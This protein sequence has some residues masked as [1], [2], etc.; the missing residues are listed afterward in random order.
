MNWPDDGTDLPVEILAAFGAD[1][2]A[3]PDTWDWT[4]LTDRLLLNEQIRLRA[5]RSAGARYASPG[6]GSMLLLNDDG[7]LMPE[8]PTSIYWPDVEQNTPV[9]AR[10]DPTVLGFEAPDAGD[11][12]DLL[13]GFADQWDPTLVPDSD[14][15]MLSVVRLTASGILR[16][17][18]QGAKPLASALS[19]RILSQGPVAYWPMEDGSDSTSAA[20]A[21]GHQPLTVIG[22]VAPQFAGSDGPAGSSPLPD[23]TSHGVLVGTVPTY[24]ATGEWQVEYWFQTDTGDSLDFTASVPLQWD[25][26]GGT[27]VAWDALLFVGQGAGNPGLGNIK[28]DIAGYAAPI[29][30]GPPGESQRLEDLAIITGPIPSTQGAWNQLRV[31]A[32][33]TSGTEIQLTAYL[34]NSLLGT[35]TDSTWTLGA[36]TSITVNPLQGDGAYATVDGVGLAGVGHVAVYDTIADFDTYYAGL[37]YPGESASSRVDRLCD[38]EGIRVTVQSG[39][40]E[41][42]GSQRPGRTLLDLL[43]DC[44]AADMGL[45]SEY[46]W[47]LHYRPRSTRINQDAALVVDLATY[48]HD[49]GTDPASVL[50]PKFDDSIVR[51]DWTM[52]RPEGARGVN[53]TDPVDIAKRGRYDD[54]ADINVATDGVLVHHAGWRVRLGTAVIRR[55]PSWPLDLAGNPQYLAAW[56]AAL[57]GDRVTRTGAPAPHPPGDIDTLLEEWS[58][59]IGPRQWMVSVGGGPYGGWTVGTVDGQPRV[60]ADGSTLAAVLNPGDSTFTLASTASN[61]VWVTGTTVTNT[62]DYPMLLRVGGDLVVASGISGPT[63]PQTVTISS[64]SALRTW[65]AGTPV[66]LYL[67]A[68]VAL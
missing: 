17:M 32:K 7:A 54:A 11:Y 9:W 3:D 31:C 47:G 33:A 57:F 44:E 12:W 65:P 52:S 38:E 62:V 24:T 35:A 68:V 50:Q 8:F 16:R 21:L 48:Q 41:S 40:S 14:G 64:W 51:N 26:P 4:T 60:A 42:M 45:L 46:R 2:T 27:V 18:S 49:G 37:G 22:A 1:L 67:P 55:Y 53:V 30:G 10:L 59:T 5:G 39:D 43:R 61:G 36:V 56:M 58:A 23:L 28:L 25:T 29:G 20:S 19:R 34:N 6:S 66:D 13:N 63:S 15:T